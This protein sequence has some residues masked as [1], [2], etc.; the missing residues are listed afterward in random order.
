M[1]E[2]IGYI[3]DFVNYRILKKDRV[4][5]Q[6]KPE[7]VNL[8]QAYFMKA[9]ISSDIHNLTCS[10]MGKQPFDA[11]KSNSDNETADRIFAEAKE[12]DDLFPGVL[13]IMF[14]QYILADPWMRESDQSTWAF[15]VMHR[16]DIDYFPDS[17]RV[18][19]VLFK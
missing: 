16:K 18:H 5:S 11:V 7:Q 9:L 13:Q 17:V 8:Y 12:K 15:R 2:L 1:K 10:R 6:V 19:N 14:E 4:Y 3:R